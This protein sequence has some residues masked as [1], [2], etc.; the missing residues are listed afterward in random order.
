MTVTNLLMAETTAP[1]T[2]FFNFETKL[3]LSV[4]FGLLVIALLVIHFLRRQPESFVNPAVRRT[5]ELRV[6]AWCM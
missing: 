1:L 2:I 3:L 6:R 4:V 5:F